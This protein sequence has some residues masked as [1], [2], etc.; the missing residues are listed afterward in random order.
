MSKWYNNIDNLGGG[1]DPGNLQSGN[2]TSSIANIIHIQGGWVTV[3]S[4]SDMYD[5]HKQRL[6]Q[7]QIIYVDHTKELFQVKR[8]P[9]GFA[10]V[11]S[12]SFHEFEWPGGDG[13]VGFPY[14]GSD[15]QHGNPAQAIITGSLLLSGSGHITASEIKADDIRLPGGGRLYFADATQNIVGNGNYIIVDGDDY[16]KLDADNEI[17]LNAP[18]VGIGT[19]FNTPHTDQIT[20][21][22]EV[23]GGIS[24]SGAITASNLQ[25]DNNINLDGTL[26]FDGFA[27]SDGNILVTSGSTTFG[28][29]ASEDIHK[30]TGS[31]FVSG[32]IHLSSQGSGDIQLFGTASHAITSSFVISSSHALFSDNAL[33][34]SYVDANNIDGNIGGEGFP[35]A[36]SDSQYSNPAQAIITGSLLLSG[37]GYITASSILLRENGNIFIGSGQTGLKKSSNTFFQSSDSNDWQ[38]NAAGKQIFHAVATEFIVNDGGRSDVNFRVEGNNKTHLIFADASTDKVAIGTNT[39]GNSLLTIDGDTSLTNITASGNISASG[40]ISA[41]SI[42]INENFQ[43]KGKVTFGTNTVTIDG[44]PGHITASGIISAS[45]VIAKFITGSLLGTSSFAD[46]AL[47]A[48]FVESSSYALTASFVESSS[49]ALTASYI[50]LPNNLLSSSIQIKDDISGSW[51]HANLLSSSIQIKDDIS[52]SWQHANL[53]SS[54]VQIKDDISGSWQGENLLSSSVQIKDDISG[55]WQHANLLSSSVQIKDDISG[56]WQHANLLSSSVQIKDDISGSWQGENF[57]K[58]SQTSSLS[59]IN[60]FPFEGNAVISGSL[61]FYNHPINT[62]ITYLNYTPTGDNLKVQKDDGIIFQANNE[63]LD[64]NTTVNNTESI[65][66]D[67]NN[68]TYFYSSSNIVINFGSAK[69]LTEVNHI[70]KPTKAPNSI[71]IYGSNEQDFITN[72]GILLSEGATTS[73]FID[74]FKISHSNP[75]DSNNDN[76]QITSSIPLFRQDKFQYYRIRYSGSINGIV[77]AVNYIGAQHIQYNEDNSSEQP[78]TLIN[79]DIISSSKILGNNGN[80]NSLEINDTLKIK[81]L[82]ISKSI[83]ENTA[84]ILDISE[85]GANFASIGTSI[86]PANT[87]LDSNSVSDQTIGAADKKWKEIYVQNTFFGGIHE[88]NLETEGLDKMQE[89]TVLSLQNGTLHPCEF[90]EDPLV[91]GVVSKESNYPIILGAEPILITGPIKAGDYIVTS[92]VKGHGK[93]INPKHIYNKQLFGKIIAQSIENGKGESYTIKAMIRKM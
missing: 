89:G 1:P 44:T 83:A 72:P 3:P 76:I 4:Q 36:G 27:F 2:D 38:L 5:I 46:Y 67:P 22:L 25:V 84:G 21:A 47:T 56:S 43:V 57:V 29:S 90:E 60:G 68:S 39:I 87:T 16:V 33:T 10:G 85:E 65:F 55:S 73:E 6:F 74:P 24:A 82:D 45:S 18:K 77:N 30:F 9:Q 23:D 34:A 79:N 48:S 15:V 59:S 52:G 8:T 32:G 80:F 51:Q 58:N 66:N 71:E 61:E 19:I 70:F 75:L 54:S 35:Y 14:A 7:H 69:K 86:L 91:M 40:F 17:K 20:N 64:S 41:S 13:G 26:S 12:K 11:I 37:S 62:S 42:S 31:L 53:L 92:N 49:H 78:T 93:G 63:D 28:D 50:S 88:I 81:N